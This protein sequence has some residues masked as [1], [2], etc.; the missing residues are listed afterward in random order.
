[1]KTKKPGVQL[2][3]ALVPSKLAGKQAYQLPKKFCP[4]CNSTG[5]FLLDPSDEFTIVADGHLE[6]PPDVWGLDYS[7]D[8][9]ACG[10][11]GELGDF[12]E[13]VEVTGKRR[14]ALLREFLKQWGR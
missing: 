6:F 14:A 4:N 1:M 7:C 9:A 13:W 11:A 5:P 8:C 10:F 2:Q 12:I 3:N